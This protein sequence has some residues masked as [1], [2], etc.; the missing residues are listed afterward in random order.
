[1]AVGFSRVRY[2]SITLIVGFLLLALLR[3]CN[4]AR[5]MAMNI[6]AQTYAEELGMK[7]ELEYPLPSGSTDEGESIKGEEDWTVGQRSCAEQTL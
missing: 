5:K 6:D 2:G 4:A 3:Q 1:M 7:L